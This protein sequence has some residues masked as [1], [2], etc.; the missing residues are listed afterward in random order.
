MT[1]EMDRLRK[2]C[3]ADDAHLLELLS[4]AGTPYDA[5]RDVDVAGHPY[6]PELLPTPKEGE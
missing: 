2:L 4:W 5:A 6:H 1:P 3:T